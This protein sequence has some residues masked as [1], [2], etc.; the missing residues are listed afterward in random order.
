MLAQILSSRGT[1][2]NSQSRYERIKQNFENNKDRMD[3][4]ELWG[5]RPCSNCVKEMVCKYGK[6]T[7]YC[8]DDKLTDEE[9]ISQMERTCMKYLIRGC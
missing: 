8:S 6:S 9:I 4:Q 3:A 7:G 1:S 2:S 5:T